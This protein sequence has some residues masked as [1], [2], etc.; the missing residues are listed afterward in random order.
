VKEVG[1][2]VFRLEGHQAVE[3]GTIRR[4]N[5]LLAFIGDVVDIRGVR[6]ERFQGGPEFL[7]PGDVGLRLFQS[8]PLCGHDDV[9]RPVAMAE[10]GCVGGDALH[11]TVAVVLNDDDGMPRG[12]LGIVR[13][14]EPL[15]LPGLL[16]LLPG[17]LSLS[18]LRSD[19]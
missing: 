13:V 3:L 2:I 7:G 18:T 16:V 8:L 10:S 15:K 6:Q 14:C 5:A 12:C 1:W 17:V 11:G 9:V 19:R 4:A